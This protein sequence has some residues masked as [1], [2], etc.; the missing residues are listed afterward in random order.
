M[1]NKSFKTRLIRFN[2]ALLTLPG[3]EVDPKVKTK[4]GFF[5]VDCSSLFVNSF[6]KPSVNFMRCPVSFLLPTNI[7]QYLSSFDQV[8]EFF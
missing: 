8:G 3:Y 4:T 5:K 6:P 7:F 1:E 2:K